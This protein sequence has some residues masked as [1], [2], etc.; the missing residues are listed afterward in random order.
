MITLLNAAP[1]TGNQG[2]SALCHS[3]VAGLSNRGATLMTVADHGRGL[4]S[5]D[6]GYAQVNLV[7]LTHHRRFWR[8]DSLRT[9]HA[10]VRAGDGPAHRPG[11]YLGREP[12]SISLAETALPTSTDQNDF[13]P[14]P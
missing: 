6:W 11:P 8:G 1:D 5:A 4:R 12:F 14:C 2:V 9:A 3:V 10:L 13:A 7:G